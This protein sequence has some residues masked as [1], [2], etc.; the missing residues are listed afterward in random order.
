MFP[1]LQFFLL[2]ITSLL[3]HIGMSNPN[4]SSTSDYVPREGVGSTFMV[5][6]GPRI[7]QFLLWMSTSCQLLYL[8]LKAFS[9]TS[10]SI[11]FPQISASIDPLPFTPVSVLGFIFMIIG[12]LGRIWC[13]RT[14]GVFFTFE[15]T[16]RH[17]HKLIRTGP[18]AYVRHPSYTF[19]CIL[20]IGWFFV[21]QRMSNFFPDRTWIH[22]QFG[23]LGFLACCLTLILGI[24]R[25]VKLEEEELEKKFGSEWTD[26]VSKTKRFIPKMI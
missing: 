10:I 1:L 5:F 26:Y 21:H 22:I 12:G 3:F 9:P 18:Y 17:T 19:V 6:V 25:R 20:V 4:R 11:F 23:P 8:Y 14:L 13:F 7:G 15:L 24:K 2:F 16:I